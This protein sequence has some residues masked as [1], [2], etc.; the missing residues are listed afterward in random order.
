[1][2]PSHVLLYVIA[3]V[4]LVGWWL[5]A[6]YG[7]VMM[8]LDTSPRRRIWVILAAIAVAVLFWVTQ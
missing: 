3:T 5:A 2:A 7:W 8:Y 4:N 1:M 6:I